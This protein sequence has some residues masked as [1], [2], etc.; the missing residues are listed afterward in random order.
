MYEKA[1]LIKE[2]KEM[3][4]DNALKETIIGLTKRSRELDVQLKKND[5]KKFW[6]RRTLQDFTESGFPTCI[7][8][9]RALFDC[10]F[11]YDY[12]SQEYDLGAGK[13]SKQD[14]CDDN[15]FRD[16]EKL[17]REGKEIL[18]SLASTLCGAPSDQEF[19]WWLLQL[20]G[21]LIRNDG[22]EAKEHLVHESIMDINNRRTSIS[23][24]MGREQ[25]MS[26]HCTK[27][28]WIQPTYF[29][30]PGNPLQMIDPEPFTY[31]LFPELTITSEN[32][33]V[34][35]DQ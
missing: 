12:N 34:I 2:A 25:E 19:K 1:H 16:E 26:S 32:N 7:Q 9:I 28:S 18:D 3:G 29:N 13:L 17:V 5:N 14:P 30:P 15:L 24:R 11:V 8:T 6:R 10:R 35:S 22:L 27:I 23:E 31:D 4:Y 20:N 33:S 21:I